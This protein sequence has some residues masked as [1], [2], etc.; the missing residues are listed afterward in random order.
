[1]RTISRLS[2]AGALCVAIATSL[3]VGAG[4]AWA[5][6][7]SW[8]CVPKTAGTAV[9][10]G[11]SAGTCG[12]ETTAVELPPPAEMTT[13]NSVLPHMQYV[14]SGVGAK[15]TIQFSGVNVQIVNDEGTTASTNGEG[16]LVLGYDPNSFGLER[17]GSHNLILGRNQGYTSYGGI[18]TGGFNLITAGDASIIG[19]EGNLASAIG[20]VVIGG[21]GNQA[22]GSSAS[23]HGG[24]KNI[25]S[26]SSSSVAGGKENKALGGQSWVGGGRKNTAEAKYSSVF[27]GK[28]LTATLEYEAIP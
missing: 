21:S 7:P 28:E 26:G 9:T 5:E 8:I 13:L 25:A 15:P 2:L 3:S 18:V 23:V 22:T 17:T 19:G 6:A 14:A 10:S 24:E 12:A 11:G 16:N 4:L 1:M 20:A 27:G